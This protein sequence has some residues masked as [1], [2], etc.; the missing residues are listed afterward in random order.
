MI[1]LVLPRLSGILDVSPIWATSLSKT[2]AE[3]IFVEYE[4]RRGGNIRRI[5][6]IASSRVRPEGAQNKAQ[7]MSNR[8]IGAVKERN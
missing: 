6:G 3:N 7:K 1:T 5:I 4:P 2:D 8:H